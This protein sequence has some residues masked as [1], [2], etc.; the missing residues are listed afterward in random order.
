MAAPEDPAAGAVRKR[1][2]QPA[3]GTFDMFRRAVAKT[4]CRV[5]I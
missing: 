2:I 1:V 3:P 4:V 5:L